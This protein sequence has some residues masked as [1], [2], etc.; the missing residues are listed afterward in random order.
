MSETAPSLSHDAQKSTAAT[1][2][3]EVYDR[4]PRGYLDYWRYMA[5]P[6]FRRRVLLD[7]LEHLRR[8][9]DAATVVDLGCGTGLFLSQV[10]EALPDAR[11]VGVDIAPRQIEVARASDPSARWYVLDLDAPDPEVPAELES[12]ADAIVASE[13]VEHLDHPRRLLASARRLAAPGGRLILST[14]SGPVRA[15]ERGVGHRRHFTA[16]EMTQL[17][18]DAGWTPV[19]VWNAGWPFHDLS[20]WW[21]NRDPDGSM[22]RFGERGY[23]WSERLVCWGL[24]QLFRLNSNRRGAQLFAVA[25]APSKGLQESTP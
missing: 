2:N 10:A 22:E 7:Q 9:G 16:D 4:L 13:L 11:R 8:T 17:L 23:G 5:A 21:A 20:K 1:L 12:S 3:E 6:R 18:R 24:R 14:Q 15:T 25:E 19:R